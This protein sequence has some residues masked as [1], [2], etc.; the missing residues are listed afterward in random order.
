MEKLSDYITRE[1]VATIGQMAHDDREFQRALLAD[2]QAA[3][4]QRFGKELVPGKQLKIVTGPDGQTR[5]FVPGVEEVIYLT[6]DEPLKATPHDELSD[7][8]LEFVSAGSCVGPQP[9]PIKG[10]G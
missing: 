1:E 8:E 4:R 10:P 2:P 5:L 9:P 6:A 3:Y 7:E